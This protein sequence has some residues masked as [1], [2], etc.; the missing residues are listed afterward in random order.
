M[1]PR[2]SRELTNRVKLKR[3]KK[4]KKLF[5]FFF[6]FFFFTLLASLHGHRSK[7]L[8]WTC[9]AYR[10]V[11]RPF[12]SVFFIDLFDLFCVFFVFKQ[13]KW[14]LMDGCCIV[15][16]QSGTQ[17]KIT[18]EPISYQSISR[19]AARETTRRDNATHTT[20]KKCRLSQ[21][22]KK[23]TALWS[24]RMKPRMNP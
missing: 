13:R 21:I 14:R 19:V 12:C 17:L 3:R 6:P 1:G 9:P 18:W 22:K 11:R 24:K 5:L 15:S 20:S 4:K 2:E 16:N 7:S 8:Q 23:D 10:K